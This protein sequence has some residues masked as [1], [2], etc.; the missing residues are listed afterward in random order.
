MT[1]CNK[2]GE[3]IIF[4]K[5]GN[6]K[7]L[8]CNPEEVQGWAIGETVVR[9]DG[10][11]IKA[12]KGGELESSWKYYYPH[13]EKCKSAEKKD[14]SMKCPYCNQPARF[15]WLSVV[16]PKATG[17]VWACFECN[18]WTKADEETQKPYGRMANKEL[19]E[20]RSKV[21]NALK[22]IIAQNFTL[23]PEGSVRTEIDAREACF[24]WIAERLNVK[25]FWLSWSTKEDC[26]KVLNICGTEDF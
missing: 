25:K 23:D 22:P 4:I 5:T 2:C 11:L 7:W 18:A 16:I 20:L 1:A 6:E 3:E 26:E 19:R 9:Q 17:R 12:V 14:N 10:L 15:S 13:W 8:A 24:R 21:F